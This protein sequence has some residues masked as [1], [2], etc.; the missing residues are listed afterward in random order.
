MYAQV[1]LNNIDENIDLKKK[2]ESMSYFTYFNRVFK[3]S[4]LDVKRV[5]IDSQARTNMV[6]KFDYQIIQSDQSDTKR[7]VHVIIIILKIEIEADYSNLVTCIC[8]HYVY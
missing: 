3:T 6:S 4:E 8:K 2:K 5:S 1:F 7:K